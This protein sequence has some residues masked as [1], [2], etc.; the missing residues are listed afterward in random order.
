MSHPAPIWLREE[1]VC[2][3]LDLPAAIDALERVLAL[4]AAGEAANLEKTHLALPHGA[5]LHALGAAIH[6]RDLAGVKSWAHTAG[7]AAPLLALWDAAEGGLLAVI[8][9]FAL[10][11]LRTAAVSGVAT[12]CL[13][14]TDADV[15]ALAGTGKQALPQ[16]AAVAAVRELRELRIFGRDPARRAALAERAR[17]TG[18]ARSVR[19]AASM[20]EATAGAGIVTLATRATAPFLEAWMLAPGAHVNAIGAITPDR[21]EVA[22][23]VL[24]RCTVVV[25]DAPVTALRLS[26]ELST[27][28]GA[29]GGERPALEALSTRVA[30]RAPRPPDADL[31]LFKAMGMGLSDVALGAEVLARARAAGRGL[32]LPPAERVAPRLR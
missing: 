14:R 28:Y 18:L 32:A 2:A 12:R 8:E 30:R 4:E 17:A 29:A 16:A 3:V 5:T 22:Q 31:T 15:M 10:G 13:A 21:A 7:G 24:G 27:W 9:A 25:A 11:Q 23:D 20:G 26:R 1:D 19:E 6:G